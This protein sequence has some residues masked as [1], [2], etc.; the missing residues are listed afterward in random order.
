MSVASAAE[1][2]R[3]LLTLRKM[4][5]YRRTEIGRRFHLGKEAF[6]QLQE[7]DALEWALEILN[8]RT[9]TVEKEKR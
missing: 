1:R 8:V 2:D 7:A 6:L 5:S 3:H 4:L 9:S